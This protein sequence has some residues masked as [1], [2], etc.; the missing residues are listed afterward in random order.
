M[1]RRLGWIGECERTQKQPFSMCSASRMQHVPKVQS[2]HLA[3]TP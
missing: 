1:G 2:R 3:L